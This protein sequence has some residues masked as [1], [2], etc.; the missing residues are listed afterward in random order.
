[1][2]TAHVTIIGDEVYDARGM[3]VNEVAASE[4]RAVAVPDREP[5]Q[6]TPMDPIDEFNGLLAR[7]IPIAHGMNDKDQR[8][9]SEFMEAARALLTA[10]TRL[11]TNEQRRFEAALRNA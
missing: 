9:A 4:T 7:A 5:A 6:V 1:M 2:R 8:R 11:P 3:R 10:T